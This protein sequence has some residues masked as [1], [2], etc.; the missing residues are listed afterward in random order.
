M[1]GIKDLSALVAEKMG[2]TKKD[3]E[4]AVRATFD[5]IVEQMG[6]NEEVSIPNFG[7][8]STKVVE[9]H[10]GRNPQTGEVIRIAAATRPVFKFSSIVKKCLNQY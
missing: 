10:D 7:K 4:T 2:V 8:F 1:V 3:A 5:V 6:K 9:A